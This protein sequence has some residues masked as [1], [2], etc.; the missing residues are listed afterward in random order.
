MSR[1]TAS[2]TSQTG[3][4]VLLARNTDTLSAG[5]PGHVYFVGP[6]DFVPRVGEAR[7]EVAVV[8]Q[9]QQALG[10]DV[11]PA[12]RHEIGRARRQQVEH[13]APLLLVAPGG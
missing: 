3:M 8:G 9:E 1:F 7:R 10:P 11:E 4:V 2:T 5:P 12:H 6:L 13:G